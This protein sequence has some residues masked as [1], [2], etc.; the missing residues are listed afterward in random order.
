MVF[1]YTLP[2]SNMRGVHKAAFV[3]ALV[4]FA[5][6]KHGAEMCWYSL[7]INRLEIMHGS[8]LK[9]CAHKRE[10]FSTM[11]DMNVLCA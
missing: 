10:M 9:C 2:F 6:K 4:Q 3:I 8:R 5:S 1:Y 7:G 11:R